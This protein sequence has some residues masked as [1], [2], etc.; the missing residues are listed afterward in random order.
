MVALFVT[1]DTTKF[2]ELI[3]WCVE[4]KSR[5]SENMAA[6]AASVAAVSGLAAYLNGKYHLGQDIKALR[7]R[8][9]ATK[10]YE[11]LGTLAI[12]LNNKSPT[13][14]ISKN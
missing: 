10:Y 6:T 9:N 14:A 8:R 4:Y 1:F 7:F 2:A 5:T 11:E 13:E 3:G 12:T